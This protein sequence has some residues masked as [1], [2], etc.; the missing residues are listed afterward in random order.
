MP[1]ASSKKGTGSK[2]G[3]RDRRSPSR[4]ST[5][6]SALTDTPAPPTPINATPTPAVPTTPL[7]KETAYLHT[8]TAVLV[9][10]DLS[11]QALIDAQSTSAKPGD[12][13]VARALHALHD[14]IR[15]TTNKFMAKR[16]EV[17]DRSIRQLAQRK[18]ERLQLVREHEMVKAEEAARAKREAEDSE[19]KKAK[20]LSKKRSHDEMDVDGEDKAGLPSV[21][22]HGVARQDGVGVND[23][24]QAPPSPS[25][26]QGT[27]AIDPMDTAESPSDSEE[28][29]A[30]PISTVPLYER[31]FGRDPT[32]FDDPTV[33]DIRPI[34]EDMGDEEKREI[35]NVLHW[36][37]SDLHDL[38]AGDP[39]DMDFSNAKPAN[40]INFSTFQTAIEP[41]IRP[42][43]EEDVA[44]LK[45]RGDRFTPYVIPQR[46]P[47][48]YKDVWAA[49]EGMT[50]V[51]PPRQAQSNPNE[52]RGAM[53]DMDD[54]VAES[55]EISM[56][57]IM[58]RLVSII[59]PVPNAAKKEEETD[60]NGDTSMVNGDETAE[61]NGQA[62]ADEQQKPLTCLP[63]DAPR[64][65]N[66]PSLDYE[67]FEA[68]A[69]QEL[70]H[71]GFLAPN[72]V[73]DFDARNDDE[74]AARLR[75]LQHELRR[76]SRL[77]NVRKA[78]VLELTEERMAM[79]EY[80]NIADDLDNQVNAAYLKRNR[81]LAK[82][83]NKK[84]SRPGQ[85]G[86]AGVAT[87]SRGVS[88]G[89]RALMQKRRDW[90]D[91]VGPV[92]GYGRPPIPGDDETIFDGDAMRRLEK[93]EREAEAGENE[94]D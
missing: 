26:P 54:T 78:R 8:A 90:I 16:G 9:S 56:G 68:R 4:H 60:A 35:Y 10:Q 34:T 93:V 89:V 58:N 51:E 55:D 29:H 33:Y 24:V 18:K 39:P 76:V 57:P 81:S 25:V 43:T 63:S 41:Y 52:A 50:G 38:T 21:G 23:G 49:E 13:P 44:Y 75:T 71:I 19:K 7:A 45:E 61:P 86:V 31:A 6:V 17:C 73:P 59:R 30:D 11:I 67:G 14:Q 69:L 22:A 91:M 72:D 82:P 64:P 85:K 83:N 65:T 66:L 27:V 94:G 47:R 20:K 2:A 70:R 48:G 37:E 42:F 3:H 80:A 5:P 88:D 1:S 28:S 62:G 53:D 12:P 79:Q 40:Q 87:A 32:K 92:V 74:V 46:G 36:P 84:G 77:N 15:D